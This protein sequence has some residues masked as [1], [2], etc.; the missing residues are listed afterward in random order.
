MGVVLLLRCLSAGRFAGHG[1]VRYGRVSE[2]NCIM[3]GEMCL[4]FP[5]SPLFS[6][7]LYLGYSD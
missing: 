4:W 6:Y 2:V 3:L 7:L 5:F 1:G